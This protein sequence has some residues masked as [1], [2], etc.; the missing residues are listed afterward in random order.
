MSA[1][2]A[3]C[4]PVDL[5]LVCTCELRALASPARGWQSF[6]QSVCRRA[7]CHAS[8]QI[9]LAG[10]RRNEGP[11]PPFA[12][13][14]APV[15]SQCVPLYPIHLVGTSARAS[16]ALKS[17][18]PSASLRHGVT[19]P[20][21]GPRLAVP[22]QAAQ[23]CGCTS[24]SSTSPG[25]SCSRLSTSGASP[26]PRPT[27]RPAASPAPSRRRGRTQRPRGRPTSGL[28][29]PLPL[30]QAC[31]LSATGPIPPLPPGA[32]QGPPH[33]A[34]GE[35]GGHPRAP[36]NRVHAPQAH[37]QPGHEGGP[38][39]RS[40]SSARLVSR[41]PASPSHRANTPPGPPAF[42]RSSKTSCWRGG[43]TCRR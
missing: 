41:P 31:S 7:P 36:G 32:S 29:A 40:L 22:P 8:T 1:T 2:R 35:A 27:A 23:Q 15:L 24:S 13:E 6:S 12:R 43:T 3:C 4:L 37:R 26:L 34:R 42:S 11:R 20:A 14:A 21:H 9:P 30:G 33:G 39:P 16:R 10:D 17:R 38:A 28:L 19:P 25:G 5:I 18:R